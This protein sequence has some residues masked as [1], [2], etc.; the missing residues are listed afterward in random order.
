MKHIVTI[1]L[2][3]LICGACFNK[4]SNLKCATKEDNTGFC[5][6]I[7]DSKTKITVPRIFN[8]ECA[9]CHSFYKNATGPKMSGLIQ[10]V[11][12]ENWIVEFITNQDS[13]INIRDKYTLDIMLWSPVEFSHNYSDISNDDLS[14][15]LE[16]VKQ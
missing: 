6:T 2:I 16:Y 4:D 11:P 10:R 1:S 3:L 8:A 9:T 13:L 12:N 15:L 5:G 14:K 7:D